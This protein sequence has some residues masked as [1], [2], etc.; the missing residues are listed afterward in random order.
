MDRRGRAVSISRGRFT[1][2]VAA[3]L[4]AGC[5]M[6]PDPYDYSGPVP[7]GSA[8]QNDFRARSN[9]ILPI[10]SR[11]MPWPPLVKRDGGVPAGVDH[12]AAT[13]GRGGLPTLADPAVA[14]ATSD[15]TD[16]ALEPTSVLVAAVEVEPVDAPPDARLAEAA[17]DTPQAA[18]TECRPE[19]PRVDRPELAETPGW[20]PRQV[21]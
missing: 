8:P 16:P 10:G 11:P 12:V 7:N 2:A 15:A 4:L 20:R 17:T 18:G 9:G 21:R 1:V 13:S 3:T 14:A 6:C 5:T 19:E